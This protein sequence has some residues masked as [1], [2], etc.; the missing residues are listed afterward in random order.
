MDKREAWITEIGIPHYFGDALKEP[1]TIIR[2]IDINVYINN[3]NIL[4]NY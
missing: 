3:M 4:I 1:P 2:G